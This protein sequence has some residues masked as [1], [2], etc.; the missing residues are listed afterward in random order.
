MLTLQQP[1]VEAARRLLDVKQD[2]VLPWTL[3]SLLQ[4][5]P[6]ECLRQASE[7]NGASLHPSARL[8]L[9]V[10]VQQASQRATGTDLDLACLHRLTEKYISDQLRW[11]HQRDLNQ[12]GLPGLFSPQE[13]LTPGAAYWDCMHPSNGQFH[14]QEPLHLALLAWSNECLFDL[15][16]RVGQDIGPLLELH[17]LTV[18]S[19]NECLWDEEYGLYLP[20]DLTCY[21]T[22]LTGSIGGILPLIADIGDQEQAEAM[23]GILE[24]NFFDPD[25][26]CFP[27]GSIFNE[28]TGIDQPDNG[29]VDPVINW[30]LFFGL[31][32][33]DFDD[34]AIHLRNDA[35]DLIGEFGFYRYY[36]HKKHYLGNRGLGVGQQV[37]TAAIFVDLMER[38]LQHPAYV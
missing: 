22:V 20:R 27:T 4:D 3:L 36:E 23:R 17:E 5:H 10:L 13:S 33:Y 18:Y 32:R 19:M 31:L 34:L 25:H 8:L 9:P 29:A 7:I 1:V 37:I 6:S 15:A 24:A 11:Y 14:V 21:D 26:Y 16:K 12:D 28:E 38:P 30:L 2:V 35:L